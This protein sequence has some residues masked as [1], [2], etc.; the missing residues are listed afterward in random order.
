MN[1]DYDA[2]SSRDEE[3][4]MINAHHDLKKK[5]W[6]N[7]TPLVLFTG[8]FLGVV[9]LAGQYSGGRGATAVISG[10]LDERA[11][12]SFDDSCISGAST[13]QLKAEED[14]ALKLINEHLTPERWKELTAP[15]D[16]SLPSG[17][18]VLENSDDSSGRSLSSCV[19][20]NSNIV[21]PL[22]H[23]GTACLRSDRIEYNGCIRVAGNNIICKRYSLGEYTNFPIAKLPVPGAT[24]TV[25]LEA[26][27]SQKWIRLCG[28]LDW[29]AWWTSDT[30]ACTPRFYIPV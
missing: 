10:I 2:I 8:L 22:S 4:P 28:V 14:N 27:V 20:L 21:G 26:R 9:F 11:M 25:E 30:K 1:K 23:A 6:I 18:E 29:W 7:N 16:T 12:A 13:E 19:N 17:V 15:L 24:A 3:S 5:D